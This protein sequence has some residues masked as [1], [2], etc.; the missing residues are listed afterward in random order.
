MHIS[1][2]VALLAALVA[3]SVRAT[4]YGYCGDGVLDTQSEYCDAGLRAFSQVNTLPW[5]GTG[6]AQASTVAAVSANYR[7][8]DFVSESQYMPLYGLMIW[9]GG[10]QQAALDMHEYGLWCASDAGAATISFSLHRTGVSTLNSASIQ[11]AY[12]DT[13]AQNLTCAV[14]MSAA[15]VQGNALSTGLHL[16]A[17]S[18][19]WTGPALSTTWALVSGSPSQGFALLPNTV[20]S[21]ECCTSTCRITRATFE[22]ADCTQSSGPSNATDLG[23][24]FFCQRSGGLCAPELPVS[25]A[26]SIP[27]CG[28]G[29]VDVGEQCDSGTVFSNVP[30]STPIFM[31]WS[32]PILANDFVP[33]LLRWKLRLNQAMP[34]LA[35]T[36]WQWSSTIAPT[37]ASFPYLFTYELACTNPVS[38]TLVITLAPQSPSS[39]P[40]F[41][42]VY[43]YFVAGSTN[44]GNYMNNLALTA[45]DVS[46]TI[47]TISGPSSISGLGSSYDILETTVI[48]TF[49]GDECCSSTCNIVGIFSQSCVTGTPATVPGSP[50]Y[51]CNTLGECLLTP[52]NTPTRTPSNTPSTT[53]TA[54]PTPTQTGTS[55]QTPTG[56]PGASPSPTQTPSNTGTSGASASETPT[57]LPS[58]SNTATGTQTGTPTQSPPPGVS[59]SATSTQ[60]GTATQ[61][62]P[63]GTS[64]SP[65]STPTSTRSASATSS[66]GASP[67]STPVTA[68]SKKPSGGD[69]AIIGAAFGAFFGVIVVIGAVAG[70]FLLYQAYAVP[71]VR[72]VS[73]QFGGL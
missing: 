10:V 49:H 59:N 50:I 67:S 73:S 68:P 20:G 14:Y 66:S 64:S 4:D 17:F 27:I 69:P 1:T 26:G 71:T 72:A 36:L 45:T 53:I 3:L 39:F 57:S 61:T 60:T 55:T 42:G 30:S 21:T 13:L 56:S 32:L 44:C 38:G 24:Q 63:P 40:Y 58:A 37:L 5:T 23:Q 62:P 54:S 35:P 70:V 19:Q 2:A 18:F 31:S 33:N 12:V 43:T 15:F 47:N 16:T 46:Y 6:T 48:A 52:S 11:W 9:Q 28:N 8:L 22:Q 51:E 41:T 7:F 29:I 34:V 65:T 25:A